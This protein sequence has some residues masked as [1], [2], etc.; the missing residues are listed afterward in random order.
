MRTRSEQ[1]RPQWESRKAEIDEDYSITGFK[2]KENFK[3]EVVEIIP[4]IVRTNRIKTGKKALDLVI[5]KS[6]MTFS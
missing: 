1:I 2:A 6:S 4:V 5:S 3:E